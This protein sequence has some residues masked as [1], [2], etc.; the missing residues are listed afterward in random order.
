MHTVSQPAVQVGAILFC[1]LGILGTSH[2]P[3]CYLLLWRPDLNTPEFFLGG[4]PG[5]ARGRG[6][7]GGREETQGENKRPLTQ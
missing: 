2:L 7:S 6:S 5:D 3:K 4:G 1:V